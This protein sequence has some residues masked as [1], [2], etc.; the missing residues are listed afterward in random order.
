MI[1]K[2]IKHNITMKKILFVILVCCISLSMSAQSGYKTI[3]IS[4][5]LEFI[6][7]SKDAYIYVSIA[8]MRKFGL[9]ASNG[10]III[11]NHKAFLLNTPIN[12]KLTEE[13]VKAITDSLHV[14][15]TG[16]IPNHFHADCMGGLK[17]LKSIGVKSYACQ[18]TIDL[19]RK[20]GLPIPQQGFK[21]SL[22]LKFGNKELYCYYP[23]EGHAPDNIVVWIPSE[24]ILF[25]GCMIKDVKSEGLGNLSDANLKEW[26]NTVSKVYTKFKDARIVIPG[27][28]AWGGTELITHTLYL[29]NKNN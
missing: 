16:F 21:D 11:S 19:A 17:Y 26:P 4:K 18:K 7:I 13:M 14:K 29:L 1:E 27:H 12:D 22:L 25:G 15:I 8:E 2:K 6:Q 5:N 20:K 9:V 10:L 28:G 24:K 3:K 23:G